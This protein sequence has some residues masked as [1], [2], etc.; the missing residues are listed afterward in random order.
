MILTFLTKKE[1]CVMTTLPFPM[2]ESILA[3]TKLD[4]D[5]DFV[6]HVA[7]L[8]MSACRRPIISTRDSVATERRLTRPEFLAATSPPNY[9][10][11]HGG[12]IFVE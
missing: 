4:L 2:P 10:I 7:I 5:T 3:A 11:H 12:L 9:R 1:A 8:K 6:K